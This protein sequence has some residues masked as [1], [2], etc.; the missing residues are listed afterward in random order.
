MVP[1]LFDEFVTR[2]FGASLIAS[3]PPSKIKDPG[4]PSLNG[5]EPSAHGRAPRAK[6][7][8]P[9]SPARPQ[10]SGSNC[11]AQ[12]FFF[13]F[14]G[15][16]P[17]MALRVSAFGMLIALQ[18]AVHAGCFL[19]PSLSS[20]CTSQRKSPLTSVLRMRDNEFSIPGGMVGM[21]G[22]VSS[23]VLLAGSPVQPAFA[24]RSGFEIFT[25]K[26][27]NCHKSGGNTVVGEN[28]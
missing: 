15:K 13:S 21:L 12:E 16:P 27:A 19:V 1:F 6:P 7:A 17:L 8:T 9:P 14:A 11:T 20:P 2:Q 5:G 25:Q 18:F 24:E 23:C 3:W 10:Q 28:L 22:I 4:G 26:C